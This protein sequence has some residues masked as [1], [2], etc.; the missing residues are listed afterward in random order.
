[1]RLAIFNE[2][3][4]LKLL[5]IAETC[6]AS[7]IIML[8]RF[9]KIKK[10]LQ[11]MVISDKWS[12]YREDDIGKAQFVKDKVLDDIW[13]DRIEYILAFTE[14]IYSMLQVAD[15]DKPCLH[16]IYE[17]WDT[18]IEKVKTIIFMYENKKEGDESIFYSVVQKI[19]VD[20]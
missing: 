1:M 15:T 6:F 13:W 7:M 4:N 20:R 3:V 11:S 19:L 16:L 2:F 14:P 5:A 17:M 9:R 10:G 18:M 12:S 8:K